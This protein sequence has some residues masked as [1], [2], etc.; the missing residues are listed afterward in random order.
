MSSSGT[1][2]TTAR[3]RSGRWVSAAPTEQAAVRAALDRQVLGRGPALLDQPL[4]RGD[5]VVEDV[6]LLAEHAGLVPVL[7]VL[8]AAA[9]VRD[10]VDAAALQEQRA[11]SGQNAGVRLM[12]KPP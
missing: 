11:A 5:E 12:L 10:R 3:N 9:Q 1:A 7:A 8:A 2:Q 6:L 4:G